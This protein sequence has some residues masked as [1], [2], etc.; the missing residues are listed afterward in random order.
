VI[1][2]LRLQVPSTEGSGSIPG[3]GTR[4]HVP[5]LKKKILGPTAKDSACHREE[6]R[7]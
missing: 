5:Q 1:Q 3:Q 7:S 2:G 4:S 6:Q